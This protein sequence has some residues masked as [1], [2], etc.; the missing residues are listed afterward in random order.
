MTTSAPEPLPSER[1]SWLPIGLVLAAIV[2]GLVVIVATRP[3]PIDCATS[4]RAR[5]PLLSTAGMAAQPDPRL[6]TLASAVDGWGPPFGKVEAGVGYDY[7]QWLHLYGLAGGVVALTKDNAAV[8]LLDAGSLKPRWALLPSTKRIAW[9]ASTKQ[10]ALLDLDA[11]QRTRVASFDV[12]TGK[13]RWC[14]DLNSK[15]RA[16][17]PVSTAFLSDGDLM[18]ALPL[19]GDLQL[20]RVAG[21]NG[22]VL[23]SVPAKSAARADFLGTLNA[24]TVIAGGVEEYRLAQPPPDRSGGAVVTAYAVKNG[25]TVW[26]WKVPKAT[27]AHVVGVSGT[28]VVISVRTGAQSALIALDQ[29]GKEV[30]RRPQHGP[31]VEATLRSDVAI[32]HSGNGLAGYDVRTGR[33][34]WSRPIPTE[35]TY[36]PYGFTLDQMPSL[37]ADHL[38]VPT[39]T[40]LRILDV[41]TGTDVGYP[42]PTDGINTT[43]WPYQ[44][45]V[46]PDQL[47]V[48]TDTGAIV[49]TRSTGG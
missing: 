16:G 15:Q 31:A 19:D 42:L 30:W 26:T 17:Q 3:D 4:T 27:I 47:G 23:W 46:T 41:H 44:L 34:L 33:V 24:T 6:N 18:V 2:A 22:R 36:F 48:V 1:R 20:A 5:S 12:A 25:S 10:F 29:H 35:P 43:Y 32:V 45:L 7:G 37:D 9:D 49:A 28:R 39:T 13:Q 40:A 21:A 11:A 14:I 38:L 8:T